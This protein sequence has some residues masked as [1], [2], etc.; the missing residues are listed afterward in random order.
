M[1][2]WPYPQIY[3]YMQKTKAFPVRPVNFYGQR[4]Q[5]KF[6]FVSFIL[7]PD[8]LWHISETKPRKAFHVWEP[9]PARVVRAPDCDLS[10][11]SK[12][13][14]S[15]ASSTH[16]PSE[17]VL[18]TNTTSSGS[19]GSTEFFP[20]TEKEKFQKNWISN[21]FMNENSSEDISLKPDPREKQI[22]IQQS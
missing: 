19:W 18:A 20:G 22:Q 12:N 11:C 16:R 10:S 13:A 9:V 21:K 17:E 15:P 1:E 4:T 2:I 6:F 5:P 14:H 8:G 7:Q 3:K